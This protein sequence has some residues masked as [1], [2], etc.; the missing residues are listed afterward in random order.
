VQS[1][2]YTASLR[3]VFWALAQLSC[4]GNSIL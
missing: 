2:V 3:A 4:L 1:L